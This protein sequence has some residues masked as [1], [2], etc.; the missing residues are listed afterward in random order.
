MKT[1]IQLPKRKFKYSIRKENVY[2]YMILVH[3]ISIAQI[4]FFKFQNWTNQHM[5]LAY[6]LLFN[7]SSWLD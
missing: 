4:K 1:E 7:E 3:V 6:H 2:K 5:S